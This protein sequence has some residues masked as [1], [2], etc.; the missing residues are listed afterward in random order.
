[1]IETLKHGQNL[2][3]ESSRLITLT[4]LDYFFAQL[5]RKAFIGTLKVVFE[6]SRRL[7]RWQALCAIANWL[8]ALDCK[9]VG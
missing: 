5:M 4:M 2:V 9:G 3:T 7:G 8:I 1:M 6:A